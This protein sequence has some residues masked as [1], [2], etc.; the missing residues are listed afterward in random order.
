MRAHGAR[1]EVGE[2]TPYYLF[3]PA[4]ARRAASVVPDAKLIVLLRN[5]VDRAYSGWQLQTAIGTETLSFADALKREPERLAGE[6]SRLVSDPS[7]SS[8]SHRHHSYVARGMYAEQ[9]E[10][11]FEH[12]HREQFLILSSEDFFADPDHT[13]QT[14]SK[15]LGVPQHDLPPAPSPRRGRSSP[16][17]DPHTR[18]R[19]ATEFEAPNLR[20]CELLGA[21]YRW[22]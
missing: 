10:R 8:F 18:A 19:L 16:Q 13:V 9:L 14:V 21:D 1:L 2:A 11:W 17:M 6:D 12:F 7:Y 15:F 3:H 20:L 22:G 5:P 4:A